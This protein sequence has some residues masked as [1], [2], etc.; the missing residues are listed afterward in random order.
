MPP[1]IDYKI[2]VPPTET[3]E[4]FRAKGRVIP[5]KTWLDLWQEEHAR[6][7]AVAGITDIAILTDIQASIDKVL[8]GPMTYEMW[9]ADILPLLKD[10]AENG[11]AP[12]NILSD[13]RLRII[14]E[15]NLRM[16]RAAGQWK[17]IQANKKSHP[18]LMYISIHDRRTRPLHKL[19][20]GTILPVDHPWWDTHYPPCGWNCR[21][22]IIQYS[23]SD[24]DRLK[25]QVSKKPP[26]DG[27]TFDYIRKDG[28]IE[29]VPRGID[30]GF[31]YNVGKA[32]LAG[33][34]D[35]LR[36]TINATAKTNLPMARAIL[37]DIVEST[38]F[39]AF[40][41]NEQQSFPVMVLGQAERQLLGTES[42][43]AVLSSATYEK[44]LLKH[45]EL[46]IDIY[47]LLLDLGEAPELIFKQN[48]QHIVLLK[49]E[50]DKWLR[51][52]IKV[53]TDGKELYVVSYF[54][55]RDAEV[56]RLRRTLKLVYQNVR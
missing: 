22:N 36:D 35:S 5:T 50:G 21:C 24:L 3:V 46:T 11:T 25:L 33:V 48:D 55:A 30:P 8:S 37:R 14:Y 34:S 12:P 51:A 31:A 13:R 6:A 2:G 27:E 38:A 1:Q 17:Q 28:V 52:T 29:N 53:T 32:H 39:D 16:A 54:M 15:T 26:N 19:W 7:F 42:S 47:R 49:M 40:L 23:Q 18:F 44:Q 9:K 20:D 10:A 45:P 56:E 4:F 43:V 41:T